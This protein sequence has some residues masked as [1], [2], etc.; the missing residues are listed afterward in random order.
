[1]KWPVGIGAKHSTGVAAVVK[2]TPGSI[3][4]FE[5]SY[6][7]A[8]ALAYFLVQNAAGDF[9]GP[10]PSNVAAAAAMK[11]DVTATNF[12]I[13][14]EPGPHSYPI[15]G[16]SWVLLYARQTDTTTG[17]ALVQLVDWMTHSGQAVANA[18]Y[19]V[20]LPPNVASFALSA[21]ETI[22]GPSGQHLLSNA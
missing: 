10:L 11:S 6:A 20:P 3:G 4:Y 2:A 5:L 17:A 9:V 16:Y 21:L 22:I 15:S 14:N 8:N 18:N 13:V 19:Y 1:M 12:S 7:E